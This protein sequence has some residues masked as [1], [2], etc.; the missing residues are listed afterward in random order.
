[1]TGRPIKKQKSD[2]RSRSRFSDLKPVLDELYSRYDIRYIASDP[3]WLVKSFTGP[4]DREIMAVLMSALA[5]GRVDQI[6]KAGQRCVELMDHQP[7]AFTERF[8]PEKEIRKWE[9]F[10]Y[11]MV[12][13]TDILRLLYSLQTVIRRHDTLQN[14]FLSHYRPDDPHLIYAWGR[15]V[16]DLKETDRK[17]WKLKKAGGTGFN[18]LLPDPEKKGA[19][20]R[21]NLMLRWLVRSDSLDLGLWKS[22]PHDKLLIPLDTHVHR[23]AL[24]LGLTKRKDVSLNTVIDITEKLK[25]LD[26]RDPVKYDFAI[27]R[28]GI[29]KQCVK[30]KNLSM[31]VICPLCKL[32]KQLRVMNLSRKKK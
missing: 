9:P 16:P 31:C 7:R 8:H 4:K 15:A 14:W 27:C 25:Q 19:C 21:P 17:G 32:C 2:A 23:I 28:L 1:M 20:K 5:F 18:H 13:G 10:Y 6:V 30:R 26:P 29:L 11:R 12:R 22:L 3:L 24:N